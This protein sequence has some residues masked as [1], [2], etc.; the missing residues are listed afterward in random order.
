[1]P[2]MFLTLFVFETLFSD[3]LFCNQ[4]LI[5]HSCCRCNTP[6]QTPRMVL[7]YVFDPHEPVT[8]DGDF[9]FLAAGLASRQIHPLWAFV[10]SASLQRPGHE[11]RASR[12]F[13]DEFI[14]GAFFCKCYT[15]VC[16]VGSTFMQHCSTSEFNFY[17]IS[18]GLFC[19]VDFDFQV[20]E[21]LSVDAPVFQRIHDDAENC[22]R[23]IEN[24]AFQQAVQKMEKKAIEKKKKKE[25]QSTAAEA[26]HDADLGRYRSA[27]SDAV[28]S[29]SAI[30]APLSSSATVTSEASSATTPP[31]FNFSQFL[32]SYLTV[33]A[34]QLVVSNSNHLD[35][36]HSLQVKST[37]MDVFEAI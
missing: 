20:F 1:M 24:D 15:S 8:K 16:L 17:L 36:L 9:S 10:L 7:C 30:A 29:P 25:M 6:T 2:R 26:L 18:D 21:L 3:D 33:D 28:L 37:F 23:G 22:R 12:R 4:V 34:S 35:S 27:T 5:Y 13:R 11:T 32:K 19:A 31:D 14:K